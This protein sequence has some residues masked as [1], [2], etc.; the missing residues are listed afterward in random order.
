MAFN[1]SGQKIPDRVST[2]AITLRVEHS[3]NPDTGGYD[4]EYSAQY[5]FEV[6]DA[7]DEVIDTQ[8]GNLIPHLTDVQRNQAL[9]FM[10]N[11]IAK[12]TAEAIGP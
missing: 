7:D 4:R 5:T 9:T 8:S 2:L 3:P 6:V 10:E 12:A 1:P 11:M